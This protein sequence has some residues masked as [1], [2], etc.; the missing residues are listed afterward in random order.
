MERGRDDKMALEAQLH[1]K[2]RQLADFQAKFDA[3]C[4]DVNTR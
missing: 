2:T 1:D 4:A 3:H